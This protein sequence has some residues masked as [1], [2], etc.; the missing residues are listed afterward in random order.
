[1]KRFY[2]LHKREHSPQLCTL[3][4]VGLGWGEV[5]HFMFCGDGVGRSWPLYVLW[6]GV[7]CGEVGH[8]M[9]C[10]VGW[11][12]G[13]SV[14]GASSKSRRFLPSL[15]T[16]FLT[17][18]RLLAMSRITFPSRA[19]KG[20]LS[21]HKEPERRLETL[22]AENL[23]WFVCMVSRFMAT[24]T[25]IDSCACCFT[26]WVTVILLV[27]F[28]ELV[29]SFLLCCV[30]VI[31]LLSLCH[32]V[33]GSFFV[34]YVEFLG[35]IAIHTIWIPFASSNWRSADTSSESDVKLLRVSNVEQSHVG[36]RA[37]SY[38]EFVCHLQLLKRS[39]HGTKRMDSH[40]HLPYCKY[41]VGVSRNN[42]VD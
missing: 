4:F 38:I 24:H 40:P 17:W 33:L 9:F 28:Y 7:G 10:K 42:V 12:E 36:H 34:E 1:M 25:F 18:F 19:H 22:E 8:F 14:Q 3:C 39:V 6:G 15:Q 2:V 31:I 30:L 5:G 20:A 26:T 32:G 23:H 21:T 35:L 16:Q 29:V 27:T 41:T 11:G 37:I 13:L